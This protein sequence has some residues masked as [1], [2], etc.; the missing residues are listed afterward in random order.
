MLDPASLL[1]SCTQCTQPPAKTDAAA[2]Q[3]ICSV[4]QTETSSPKPIAGCP[5]P[6]IALSPDW[7]G[8]YAIRSAVQ[9]LAA[10]P[11]L[12]FTAKVAVNPPVT[13]TE[14]QQPALSA[15]TAAAPAQPQPRLRLG[16]RGA[17]V[18]QLQTQLQQLGYRP[19]PVDG[20]YE[21]LT[22][23][24]VLAFQRDRGL[25][26]D[27]IVGAN[28]WAALTKAP[29]RQTNQPP[30]TTPALTEARPQTPDDA[31]NTTEA[32]APT[33]VPQPAS[34]DPVAAPLTVTAA[35]L[36]PVVPT[37]EPSP[38]LAVPATSE[39]EEDSAKERWILVWGIIHIG[40]WIL[41]AQQTSSSVIRLSRFS[42][43][44][45]KL[46]P[47]SLLP[48]LKL[49]QP[50]KTPPR[51]RRS[52]ANRILSVNLPSG[53][54]LSSRDG[55]TPVATLLTNDLY[56]GASY[57]YSLIDDASQRFVLREDELLLLNHRFSEADLDT[58]YE[59]VVR[60]I[61]SAGGFVDQRFEI[62]L[63]RSQPA[64]RQRFSPLLAG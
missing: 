4:E 53:E 40:G 45:P 39:L 21:Q 25:K 38:L 20:R 32:I 41:I 7:S 13:E 42:R 16:S 14:P 24:A 18:R 49:K 52:S 29:P 34:P 48:Q 22:H 31:D 27:G 11:V 61:D 6:E 5:S 33:E 8:A 30:Q 15:S 54:A 59:V 35:P 26:A 37:S 2:N 1:L 51:S 43:N 28:T 3:P 50:P 46:R 23:T 17:E 56:T 10:N 47:A 36:S 63:K 55:E 19:G 9:V 57:R 64:N 60:R 62:H 44:F 12:K 58:Q